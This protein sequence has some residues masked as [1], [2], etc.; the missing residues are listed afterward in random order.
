MAQTSDVAKPAVPRG[1]KILLGISLAINLA[2]IGV[3]SGA[4]FRKGD[5]GPRRG[6]G[7]GQ[8]HYARPYIQALP[9]EERRAIFEASRAAKKG[10][11]RASRR[12][13]YQK[14]IDILRSEIF[15][16]PA[17]EVVLS[18][19]M[20]VTSRAQNSVQEQWLNRIEEMDFQER[21]AYADAVEEV[22]K[23]GPSHK[24]K[25]EPN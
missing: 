6:S 19:Q 8:A 4:I 9:R 2:V 16:R 7:G 21:S 13:M 25:P 11:D 15:D 17:V 5:D 20:E 3:V 23:R 14:V 24:R 18:E 10:V 22:L 12:A 1:F